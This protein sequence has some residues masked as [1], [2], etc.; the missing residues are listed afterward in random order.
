MS[1][2]QVIYIVDNYSSY[3]DN[4][5]L[6]GL[7]EKVHKDE[8]I[9]TSSTL[10]PKEFRELVQLIIDE[11]GGDVVNKVYKRKALYNCY[12]RI[13]YGVHF[14]DRVVMTKDDF[15]EY[16]FEG[17][18][19]ENGVI[20]KSDELPAGALEYANMF[21]VVDLTNV[22]RIMEGNLHYTKRSN[23]TVKLAKDLGFALAATLNFFPDTVVEYP[24]T[25]E[26]FSKLIDGIS[27]RWSPYPEAMYILK[28][29]MKKNHIK[30][31]DKDWSLANW[32]SA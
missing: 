20:I 13:Y 16:E 27:K 14:N 28:D 5:D 29:L 19:F 32:H 6:H 31:T 22:K 15:S 23:C 17:A 30:C 3:I 4:L 11:L 26:E 1:K 24:G 7:L 8:N 12:D 25:H 18:T 10:P 2:K 21:G 9:K